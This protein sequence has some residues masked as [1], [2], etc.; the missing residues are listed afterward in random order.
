MPFYSFRD[1]V[2]CFQIQVSRSHFQRRG[3]S[4]DESSKLSPISSRTESSKSSDSS[5]SESSSSS[6]SE[7]ASSESESSSDSEAENEGEDETEEEKRRKRRLLDLVDMEDLEA[8]HKL[9][10]KYCHHTCSAGFI[11]AMQQ[12]YT[13]MSLKV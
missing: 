11:S 9:R 8:L 10:Y 13:E 3:E 2:C 6:S 7:S 12:N 4:D 1:I 5:S